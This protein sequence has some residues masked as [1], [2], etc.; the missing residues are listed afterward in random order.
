[1]EIA[2]IVADIYKIA[3]GYQ[4]RAPLSWMFIHT[5]VIATGMWALRK[6]NQAVA[7]KGLAAPRAA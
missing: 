5:L 3:R 1:M 2:G 7:E 4:L 6:S